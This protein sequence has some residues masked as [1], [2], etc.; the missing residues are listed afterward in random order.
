MTTRTRNDILEQAFPEGI[1][2]GT[3]ALTVQG[4]VEANVKNGVEHEGSTLLT[5]VAAG[6][7]NDTIFLTGN[8]PVALKARIIAYSGTGVSGFIFEGATYTGGT[9]AVYQNANAINP[10]AGLSQIIVGATVTDDGTLVFAPTHSIGN[11]SQQGK[12]TSG[13][14]LGGER[15]LQPNTAYLL[16]LTSLDS[17]PQDIASFLSWYEGGLDLPLP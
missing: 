7:S 12:G 15:I 1:A 2:E 14:L 5:G 6:A 8:L 9:P 10:V 17:Q 4:Y 11:Q 16:R 13:T 3:R